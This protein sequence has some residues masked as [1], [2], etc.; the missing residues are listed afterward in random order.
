MSCATVSHGTSL[1]YQTKCNLCPACA[2]GD[3]APLLKRVLRFRCIWRRR[4]ETTLASVLSVM[5][6]AQPHIADTSMH[7]HTSLCFMAHSC[8]NSPC[9]LFDAWK[10]QL[11][12]ACQHCTTNATN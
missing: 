10:F 5:N 8:A 7:V 2:E 1:Y 4:D 11:V 3:P 6:G 9:L 12:R